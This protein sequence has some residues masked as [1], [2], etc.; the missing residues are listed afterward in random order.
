MSEK[1]L[2]V[3]Y[4][5]TYRA[6]YARNKIIIAGLRQN[7]ITVI[8][9]HEQLWQSVEDRV[10]TASGG[11]LRPGFWW[12]VVKTYATL[13]RRYLKVEDHDVLMVGYPGH[14]DV[15]FA[16]ALARFK[17]KPLAWDVLNSLYLITSE[18]GITE[19]SPITVSLIRK[20]ERRACMLPDMLFLDTENFVTWFGETHKIPTG[21]FRLIQIGVDER[22]FSP[23][24]KTITDD[25]F[26]VIYYG[27]YIPN[28]GVEYIVEAA[29]LLTDDPSILIEM[30]GSGPEQEKAIQLARKYNLENIHFIVEDDS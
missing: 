26:R 6:E 25:R 8:E 21:R 7:G 18:R 13:L 28:H 23:L 3:C 4:L 12:R 20:V 16:W 2:T 22:F 30:I 29:H 27:T 5:G 14:F 10:G 9:C 15:F 1:P 24:E 17:K 19:R 11:W